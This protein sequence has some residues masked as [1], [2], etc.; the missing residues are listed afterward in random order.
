MESICSTT[1][2]GNFCG[3][4]AESRDFDVDFETDAFEADFDRETDFDDLLDD[5]DDF[6]ISEIELVFFV[7]FFINLFAP[8]AKESDG[9]SE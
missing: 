6:E 4:D 2:F 3:F 8:R 9:S 7:S 5:L 1:G